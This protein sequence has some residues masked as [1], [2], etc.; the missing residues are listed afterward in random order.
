MVSVPAS[1]AGGRAFESH[2]PDQMSAEV[3]CDR[4]RAAEMPLAA[5][6]V[7]LRLAPG[8]IARLRSEWPRGL[9]QDTW[10]SASEIAGSSPAGATTV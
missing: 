3:A 8:G 10:F 1:E 6:P 7:Q 2:L 5:A 9:M 4:S